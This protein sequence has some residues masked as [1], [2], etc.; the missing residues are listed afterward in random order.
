MRK[1]KCANL[2]PRPQPLMTK[3]WDSFFSICQSVALCHQERCPGI[4][5]WQKWGRSL[6]DEAKKLDF[7]IFKKSGLWLTIDKRRTLRKTWQTH[8]KK[9]QLKQMTTKL[10]FE[11]VS[12]K[13]STKCTGAD[14]ITHLLLKVRKSQKQIC[15]LKF[16]PSHFFLD[17]NENIC[18]TSLNISV[19]FLEEIGTE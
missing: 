9:S 4:I 10:F 5:L 12:L 7:K 17:P 18:L 15:I 3:L 16:L 14:R 13:K 6:Y 8:R 11:K 2:Y 1:Q 19:R